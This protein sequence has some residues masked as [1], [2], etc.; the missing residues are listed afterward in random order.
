[1]PSATEFE[2]KQ[3]IDQTRAATGMQLY[4][5]EEKLG[6]KKLGKILRSIDKKNNSTTMPRNE[7]SDYE[8]QTLRKAFALLLKATDETELTLKEVT[9]ILTEA[10]ALVPL[11]IIQTFSP[12]EIGVVEQN[13]LIASAIALS[14]NLRFKIL[15]LL[16]EK[17]IW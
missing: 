15:F 6:V 2:Q 14:K 8:T 9:E 12:I 7:I 1:M 16:L 11:S 3:L 5:L 10:N 17:K 4:R 13:R